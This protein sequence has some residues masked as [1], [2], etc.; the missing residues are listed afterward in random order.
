MSFKFCLVCSRKRSVYLKGLEKIP[1]DLLEF[2]IKAHW[3]E[4]VDRVEKLQHVEESEAEVPG[5][6]IWGAD[7]V[8]RPGREEDEACAHK[9]CT[10][11]LIAGYFDLDGWSCCLS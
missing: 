11:C 9:L 1:V 6:G 5:E 7:R 8:P 4:A 10:L 3:P 2:G